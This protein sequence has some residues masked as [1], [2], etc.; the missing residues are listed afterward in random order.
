MNSSMPSAI[1]EVDLSLPF[2]TLDR[3]DACERCMLVFRWRRRVVGR[4]FVDVRDTKVDARTVAAAA[5]QLGSA[6]GPRLAC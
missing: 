6:P 1:R 3:I 5:A 2:E 4:A